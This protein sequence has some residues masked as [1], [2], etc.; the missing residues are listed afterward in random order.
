M[1]N[2]IH[3]WPEDLIKGNG[4]I[5]SYVTVE[6]PN[7]ERFYL[8]YHIS[9]RYQALLTKT[10]DPFAVAMI[11]PAMRQS[12]DLIVHGAVSLS[13][14]RNL[15]EF[16]R[17]WT[18]WLPERYTKIQIQPDV[19]LKLPKVNDTDKA[20]AAF[21]GGIDSC[22]T[23]WSHGND[24]SDR[25]AHNLQAGVMIHGFDIALEESET[26]T[27]AADKSK[28]ILDSLGIE[29]I[30]VATN[31]RKLGD[32]WGDTHIAALVSCLMMFEGG[33]DVG[34]ISASPSYDNISVTPPW[35]SNP[36]TDR[37]LSSDNF[38]IVHDGTAYCR[39]EKIRQIADWPEAMRNLRVC[40]EGEQKDRNCGVCEKCV[41]TILSFKALGLELPEC[42][43]QDISN[44]Q[45]AEIKVLDQP[46]LFA[47][48]KILKRAK[49]SGI[50]ESWVDTLEKCIKYN[51][52]QLGERKPWQKL[53]K[54][55]GFRRHLHRLG[56]GASK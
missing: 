37:M 49:D 43:E 54:K 15:E 29:L 56:I 25:L 52:R 32:D 5:T 50:S 8:W 38:E 12:S 10:I 47:Y 53:G 46:H 20:I 33:F 11:F 51:Q 24:N 19:E 35:G 14:L 42:F 22:F 36:I 2:Q 6:W 31:F 1:S 48:A 27:K 17:A 55:I 39:A 7:K 44:S 30:T 28:R 40:W 9:E 26:F 13:L 3:L 21:S 18:C 41:R 4:Q 45:I 23:A 34:L 16:Q